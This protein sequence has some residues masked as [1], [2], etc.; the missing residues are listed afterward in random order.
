MKPVLPTDTP[1]R[2]GH[3]PALLLILLAGIV[4][5]ANTLH[6]PFVMDDAAIGG[7]GP[8]SPLHHLLHGTARRIAD[9]TFSLNYRLHAMNVAGYHI[10][11]LAIHLAAAVTLYA[12]TFSA[13][14]ALQ[15]PVPA[16]EHDGF[17][18]RFVPLATALLFVLH[19]VQTQSVT[20]I[21]QRYTSLATLFYLLAALLYVRSRLLHEEGASLICRT[22][23]AAG[24]VV[25]GLL[26]LGSKQIAAT[27]PLMLIVLEVALFRGR[28]LG[29]RL[30]LFCGIGAAL[31]LLSFLALGVNGSLQ[32]AAYDLRHATAEDSNTSRL[33]YFLTQT[34][35]VVLYL[36]LLLV[37]YG[38]SI[39]HD[40]GLSTVVT[41]AVLGSLAL[42]GGLIAT[43][44][45]LIRRSEQ[46]LSRLAALGICWFYVALIV[47][48]SIFPITD[49]VFEHRIYLPSAGFFLAVA[50]ITAG[51]IRNQRGAWGVLVM[52]CLVLGGLTIAR[53]RLWNNRLHL[54]QDTVAK[55]PGRYLAWANLAGEYLSLGHPDPAIRAYIRTLELNPGLHA[56][57]QARL[58]IALLQL[59]QFSGRVTPGQ[60]NPTD[61]SE[62]VFYKNMSNRLAILFN[63]QGVAYEY[64]GQPAKADTFYRQALWADRDYDLA[65][66]NWG[67]LA[68]SKGDGG[69]S[70][71]AL[72][73]LQ[74]LG[75][76]LGE[77]LKGEMGR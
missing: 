66:Y 48:S 73:E 12:L 51:L 61:T 28:L 56:S 24:C 26:A 38:Q 52:V 67:V 64:L 46:P 77:K 8:A 32:D 39:F 55:A 17:L 41:P 30:V 9:I 14:H 31:L 1:P 76:P 34:R 36:R 16:R 15:R 7:L 4:A 74:R 50:A 20:Y 54:W 27:L 70:A 43:A 47:E 57:V 13:L 59:K 6:V 3:L 58:G 21:I 42:H 33:A 18:P 5:Y 44:I 25:A 75:S 11:N 69:Q 63:N 23:P 68:K 19:P 62:K 45:L 37:P 29:R 49:L 72:R 10:V 53:N 40:V 65:W 2:R 71:M 60:G 22:V 35:V